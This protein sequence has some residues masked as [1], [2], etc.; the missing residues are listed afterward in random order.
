[1]TRPCVRGAVVLALLVLP[2]LAW[3][4]GPQRAT[5]NETA[6]A[7]NAVAVATSRGCWLELGHACIVSDL[8]RL[9]VVDDVVRYRFKVRIGP[10]PFDVIRMHRVVRERRPF[11]PARTSEALFTLHGSGFGFEY[12]FLA[13]VATG[14]RPPA[15]AMPVFLAQRG[16]DVWG[17]DLG[18]VLVPPDTKDLSFFADWGLDKEV[19]QTRAGL[20]IARAIRALT[21]GDAGR[22]DFL[23]WS[24]GGLIGYVL[25]SSESQLPAWRRHVKRFIPVDMVMKFEPGTVPDWVCPT[26]DWYKARH[27][28]GD[29][30]D[31]YSYYATIGALAIS[32][33]TATSPDFAPLTNE[34]AILYLGTAPG[35]PT[36]AFHLVAGVFDEGGTP[37]GLEY[38]Q[39]DL[40]VYAYAGGVSLDGMVW[41]ASV[42]TAVDQY[43]IWCDATDVPFDNHLGD[44]RIPTFFLGT[45]SMGP[46]GVYSTTLLGSRD[47]TTR[48]VSLKPAGQEANDYGHWDLWLADNAAKLVW[49]PILDWLKKH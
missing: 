43:G 22:M 45:T 6:R 11:V 37:I 2:V 5:P 17:M 13:N 44:V 10:G 14:L 20:G 36:P 24:Y 30:A 29:Y 4:Q 23:G 9:P 15:Q 48:I 3:A 46:A 21:S 8:E 7:R 39:K 35:G 16:V 26:A 38:T 19:A 18:W 47:V 42:L 49:Q 33:P 1:M 34:Q 41:W 28:S 31:D 25:V 32:D 27:E 40:F 12:S